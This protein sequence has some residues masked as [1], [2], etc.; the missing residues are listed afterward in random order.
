[1]EKVTVTFQRNDSAIERTLNIS[2]HEKFG[3]FRK[4]VQTLLGLRD[5]LSCQLVLKRTGKELVDS[6][7]PTEAGIKQGD[8]LILVSPSLSKTDS[9]YRATSHSPTGFSKLQSETSTSTKPQSLVTYRLQ[10]IILSDGQQPET[11]N[12]PIELTEFYE[13]NPQRF[14]SDSN[15]RERQNFVTALQEK[16]PTELQTFEI[17]KILRD[18]CDDISLGYRITT[19]KI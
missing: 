4:E 14:F 1:M 7:T 10:L 13:D 15:A 8:T 11:H 5:D 19:V 16:A 6:L 3:E 9:S 12:Y 18:W 2:L 17:D